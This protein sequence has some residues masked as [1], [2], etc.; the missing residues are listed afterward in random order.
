MKKDT[1]MM[2]ERDLGSA[3]S[4]VVFFLPPSFHQLLHNIPDR[5]FFSISFPCS[6]LPLTLVISLEELLVLCTFQGQPQS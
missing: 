2:R 1:S 4:P 3:L 5:Y 6:S